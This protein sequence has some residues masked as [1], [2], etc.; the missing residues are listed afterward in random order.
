MPK[1]TFKEYIPA[2]A[3]VIVDY[4]APPKERVKFEYPKK[5]WTWKKGTLRIIFP[6]LLMYWMFIGVFELMVLFS[7]ILGFY[8]GLFIISP[9]VRTVIY[10]AI[11]P[12]K[13]IT[14]SA[15][16]SIFQPINI[17]AIHPFQFL[18]NN[19]PNTIFLITILVLPIVTTYYFYK[20]K[21][22]ASEI[23]PK[24]NYDLYMVGSFGY[25]RKMIT[26]TP[27]DV[28]DNIFVLPRFNNVYLDYKTTGDFSKNLERIEILEYPY[29]YR[30]EKG[31]KEKV[32]NQYVWRSVF[33]FKQKPKN[34]K[35][36]IIYI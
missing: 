30:Y 18:L 20:N 14:P 27:E 5:G 17:S 2:N 9:F 11:F 24:L 6:T 31:N 29:N 25:G 3:R 22:K 34:G 1:E 21:E 15:P 16:T 36:D 10:Y 28:N 13:V 23:M 35:L 33:R 4:T 7:V 12:P 32:I 26:A 19:I 8:A